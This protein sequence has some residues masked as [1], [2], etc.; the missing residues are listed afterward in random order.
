MSKSLESLNATRLPFRIAMSRPFSSKVK[1]S[2]VEGVVAVDLVLILAGVPG[3][4]GIPGVI[5]VR[6]V[7]VGVGVAGV[8][9]VGGA[10]VIDGTGAGVVADGDRGTAS[11]E[12]QT[13]S[14]I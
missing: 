9:G 8:C 2:A 10:G 6:V 7:G 4:V 11:E 3:V 5:G 1:S 12:P 14:H 13:H